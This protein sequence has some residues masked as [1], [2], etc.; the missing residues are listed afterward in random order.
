MFNWISNACIVLAGQ[1]G[2]LYVNST[3]SMVIAQVERALCA[4]NITPTTS[5]HN[6]HS[7]LCPHCTFIF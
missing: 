1:A 3:I 2:P 5:I 6:Y 4:P 7:S